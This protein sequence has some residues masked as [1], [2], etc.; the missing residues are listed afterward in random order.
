[1]LNLQCKIEI[2]SK[3]TQKTVTF[4][5]ANSIEVKTSCLIKS[6]KSRLSHPNGI[7]INLLIF[8]LFPLFCI[9]IFV[10]LQ[11]DSD[12]NRA[13]PLEGGVDVFGVTFFYALE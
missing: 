9:K 5:Y 13:K 2:R 7:N 11:R 10:F 4:D 6:K 12:V 8:F 3:S 1:M